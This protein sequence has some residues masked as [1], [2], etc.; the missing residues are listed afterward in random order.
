[1]VAAGGRSR[2]RGSRVRA[3]GPGLARG[4]HRCHRGRLHGGLARVVSPGGLQRT[5]AARGAARGL[6]GDGHAAR[7]C[8]RRR[9]LDHRR[10]LLRLGPGHRRVSARAASTPTP[11]RSSWVAATAS[12]RA[13]R[14]APS[15]CGRAR[16][17]WPASATI[18][19]SSPAARSSTGRRASPTDGSSPCPRPTRSRS[20]PTPACVMRPCRSVAT[21]PIA[22]RPP[23]WTPAR[24]CAPRSP[25][26][27][28]CWARTSTASRSAS[29]PARGPSP[30]PTQRQAHGVFAGAGAWP[31]RLLD[32]EETG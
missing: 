15:A 13:R 16:P 28:P 25:R 31:R 3:R 9:R 19:R 5:A 18:S 30:A 10:S 22:A 4:P 14:R 6:R 11:T 1:M 32:D 20:R 26:S 7:T 17:R 8:L 21:W 29:P 12:M 23:G 24:R 2:G 27:A